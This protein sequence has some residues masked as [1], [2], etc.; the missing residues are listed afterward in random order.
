MEHYYSPSGDVSI[1]ELETVRSID[2]AT[3]SRFALPPDMT[4]AL[5]AADGQAGLDPSSVLKRFTASG[6]SQY[7]ERRDAFGK[8]GTSGL[9]RYLNLG[10][11]SARTVYE[12]VLG[13]PGS[14][15][16]IRQ[17]AWRD[18][19]LYQAVYNADFFSYEKR[20]D[21][22]PLTGRY[23]EAWSRGETGVPI[24]DAAMAQLNQ[25]GE[26][27]N[28]LRM[29]AAMF[30]TKNLLCPFTLGEAYF[31]KQ[32]ADYDNTLNRGGWLWS[33]S[34]GYDAAPYFRIMNPTTQSAAHD[35]TGAYIRTWLPRFAHL[36]DREIHHPASHAIV[37]LKASRARAIE[38]YK[39]ILGYNK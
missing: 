10:A 5:E 23:F 25:T 26:L 13:K 34:L 20:Y 3:A 29:V 30:L 38:V 33:S 15:S 14:E 24:I 18:F 1:R 7:N 2:E 37:D 31:R 28:R 17:L 19:Y 6:L 22:S 4:A 21:L 32:L 12:A 35:P 27:P 36:S 9:S 39:G 11:L 16:W 8:A